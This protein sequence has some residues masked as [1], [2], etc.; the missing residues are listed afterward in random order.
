MSVS[1]WKPIVIHPTPLEDDTGIAATN[2]YGDY[3]DYG[4]VVNTLH[5]WQHLQTAVAETMPERLRQSQTHRSRAWEALARG[6]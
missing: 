3:G 5:G 1:N 4:K 6:R 2:P